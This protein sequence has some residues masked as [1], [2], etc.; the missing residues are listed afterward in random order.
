MSQ[1]Q[2][3]HRY[4]K[5]LIDLSNDQ[6]ELEK[7]YEDVLTIAEVCKNVEF[8]AMLKSP[9][10]HTDKKLAIMKSLFEGKVQKLSLQFIQLLVSKSREGL[11]DSISKAFIEQYKEIKKIKSATLITAK[12]LNESELNTIKSKFSFWLKEGETM[13]LSQKVDTKLIGGFILEMGDKN[14]DTS[15]KRQL[16]ELKENLY[17]TSYISLVERR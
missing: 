5:S 4:A 15:I 13:E 10:V 11:L 14:Y 7:V 6:K 16:N 2:I 8:T 1:L 12:E 9:I 3:S 17:D